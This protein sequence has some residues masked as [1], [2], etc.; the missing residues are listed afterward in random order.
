MQHILLLQMTFKTFLNRTT[1]A[2]E[3]KKL[4][5]VTPAISTDT[6]VKILSQQVQHMARKKR[7]GPIKK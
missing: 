2:Q 7:T 4:N 1:K 3:C 6:S 5:K